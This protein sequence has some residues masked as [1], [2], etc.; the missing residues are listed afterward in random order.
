MFNKIL[1]ANRGEIAVR[2]ERTCQELGIR[3]VALY[4][5]ADQGS[6]HVRLADEC[7]L[8]ETR[9]GFVNTETILRIA[10]EKGADAVHPGYGFLA[11]EAAFIRA[12]QAAGLTFIGPPPEVVAP[13]R[14]KLTA[15]ERVRAAGF[16]TPEHSPRSYGL[17]ELAALKAET[18]R[19]GYPLTIKSLYG[20]RG[21]GERMV[22][23]PERLEKAL[24]RAQSEALVIYGSRS[25]FLERSILPA[26]QVAVQIVADAHGNMIHL[27]EREGSLLQ[28][29]QKLVEESPSPALTPAQ[30]AELWRTALEIARLFNYQGI[31]TVEFLLDRDGRFYFTEIKS[32][33]QMDAPLAEMVSRRDLVREQIRIAAGEPL[34]IT[35]E[36][37]HLQGWAMQ[38]HLRAEDPAANFMPAPGRL[39]RVRLPSGPEVRVDT[40]VYSGC[41]VPPQYDP[42]IAKMVTWGAG[43][44]ECRGRMARLLDEIKLTG[45]PTNVARLQQI[46]RDPAFQRGEYDT[47][48]LE[49][50]IVE[51]AEADTRLRDL[52]IA[53]AIFYARANQIPQPSLPERLRTGWHRDSRRLS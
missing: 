29:N 9:D 14:D 44:E 36:D 21:R 8:L 31:G 46:V 51:E 2:I 42:L 23:G 7:V 49:R 15:L 20:G 33:I 18:E 39:R 1:I 10:R 38:A 5:A 53:G 19:I 22:P 45:T 12:C 47:T 41:D 6:L 17:G 26:H 43:R 24:H 27:G 13:A 30:R 48:F 28:G 35:Q 16:S 11:E 50:A 52:A 37:V 3:T 34:G 25:V 4:E 32:R 40:Y